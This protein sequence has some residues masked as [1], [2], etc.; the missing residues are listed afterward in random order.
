[1]AFR[2]W[3]HDGKKDWKDNYIEYNIYKNTMGK[4]NSSS[5]YF[6]S[7]DGTSTLGA[8]IGIIVVFLLLGGIISLFTPKCIVDGCS[9]EKE[10][11]SNYCYYHEN[12]EIY[13]IH[14]KQTKQQL[15][16]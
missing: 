8:I 4:N 14:V 6:S 13:K 1:M 5:G 9:S 3:N 15:K 7:G 16:E 12:S 2:D 10:K 11:G